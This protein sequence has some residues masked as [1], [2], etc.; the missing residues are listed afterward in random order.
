VALRRARLGWIGALVCGLMLPV[1]VNGANAAADPGANSSPPDLSAP[2]RPATPAESAHLAPQTPAGISVFTID[3][4][5]AAS[6]SGGSEPSLAVN[7][8]NPNEIAITRFGSP[9]PSNAAVL[10]STDGGLTWANR[11]TIPVPPAVAGTTGCPCDQTIDFGRDGRLYGTFLTAAGAGNTRIVTGSTTDITS[12]AAW[13]WNGNP[14]QVTTAPRTNVDQPWLLVNRDPTTAAQDNVY[15]AYDDFGAGPDPRVSVSYG[16]NPVNI[17]Q[18]QK[19]GTA[20]PLVTNPG[21][22]MAA[23]PRNGAMYVLYEQSSGGAQPKSVTYRLNRSTNGGATWSLNGNADGLVV[24]TVNSDQAPGF[25]FGGVNAL[26]GGIDHAAVDPSNGDVYVVYGQ[27]VAGGNRIRIRRLQDDGVGGL[28]VG[29][30]SDVSASTDAALPSVAVATDGTVG[31]LY[32]S[33]DGM[34]GGFPQFTAHLATSSNKGATFSDTT[35]ETFLSPQTNQGTGCPSPNN[36]P[37]RQRVLGDYQQ[38]KAV[39]STF[40]G[41]FSGNSAGFGSATSRIDSVFFKVTSAPPACTASLTGDV[42]GP[43]TVASGGHLCLNGARAIGS[44]TVNAGG[45]LTV[46]NSQVSKGIVSTGAVFLQVC[47]S[48]VTDGITVSGSRGSV[49]VG[50]PA[51]GCAANQISGS[52]VTLT[53]SLAGLVLGGNTSTGSVAVTDNVGGTV[54]VKANRIQVNLSCSGNVPAP[55]HAGQP[56]TVVAGAKSGQCAAL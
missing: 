46:T 43:F 50:D 45:A 26:L 11:L 53:G 4:S 10:H 56:N 25:K 1:T 55:G 32:D 14:A 8:A 38:I 31:V 30:A 35:L 40:F 23:D 49:I 7:P 18:D 52:G 12:A 33:F 34:S 22:R 47:G 51:A 41:V 42:S 21:L 15:V 27:D 19:A 48:K 37:A 44:I 6:T 54:V 24:D 13:A 36:C 17:T 3:P 29:A 39:G 28:T 9:W 16:A 20:S 2:T 5:I